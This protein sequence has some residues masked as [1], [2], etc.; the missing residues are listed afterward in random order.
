MMAPAAGFYKNAETGRKQV[1]VAYVLNVEE[2]KQAV[3]CLRAALEAYPGKVSVEQAA[4]SGQ[5]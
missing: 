5:V 3:D 1:R 4:T 2:L